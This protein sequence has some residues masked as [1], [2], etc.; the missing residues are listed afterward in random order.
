MALD[1]RFIP[2]FYF[3]E[4]LRDKVTGLPLSNGIVTFYKDQAR[5]EL[6]KIYRISGTPPNYQYD[7]LPNPLT[8]SSVG[9]F[10]D[11]SGND[12]VVYFFPYDTEPDEPTGNIELYYITVEDEL[13]NPQWDR[14]GQPNIDESSI[15]TLNDDNFI[16]NAQFRLFKSS[17]ITLDETSIKNIAYLWDFEKSNT[18]GT[19][20]ATLTEF[21]TNLDVEGT[22]T[23][24]VNYACTSA[25]TGESYKDFVYTIPDVNT[26][27]NK[28]IR[29]SLLA[30][31]TSGAPITIEFKQYFGSGGSADVDATLATFTLTPVFTKY[32]SSAYTVPSVSGK[33]IGSG[34]YIQLRIRMPLNS[35]SSVDFTNAQLNL[36]TDI[37]TFKQLEYERNV[38]ETIGSLLPIP[39]DNDCFSRL[40]WNGEQFVFDNETGKLYMGFD[41]ERSGYILCN[42]ATYKSGDYV[43]DSNNKVKYRRLWQHWEE[44]TGDTLMSGN[45]FGYGTNG[46][47]PSVRYNNFATFIITK[48]KTAITAWADGTTGFS[49]SQF[50]VGADYGCTTTLSFNFELTGTNYKY[51]PP[52]YSFVVENDTVG[53]VGAP[54]VGTMPGSF[55]I[56]ILQTGDATHAQIAQ[57]EFDYSPADI[58]SLGGKYFTYT[59]VT[60]SLYVWFRV[61]DAGTDPAPG[62]T[63]IMV[64]IDSS[65]IQDGQSLS[66]LVA[67]MMNGCGTNTVTFTDA[68]SITPGSY[69]TIYNDGE[70]YVFYYVIDGV[71]SAP[72]VPGATA[73]IN[74]EIE[75]SWVAGQVMAQTEKEIR[76]I[77]FQVP[78]FRGLGVRGTD[79]SR[80][81]DPNAADRYTR[82]DMIGRDHV[83][84]L[85]RDE[86]R[87]HDHEVK[88]DFTHDVDAAVNWYGYVKNSDDY[89]PEVT[90]AVGGDESRMVNMN[91]NIFVKY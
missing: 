54:T 74:I 12:I 45:A 7:E 71:G 13:S 37:Y 17:S 73:I 14:E 91:V 89:G 10:M 85:Q 40:V 9:T 43:P 23:Y 57:I 36:G 65:H 35:I 21:P 70:N 67:Y 26:F 69:F 50:M 90:S 11:N 79:S 4:T 19:D 30:R 72:T 25:G 41:S 39:T 42:G 48:P 28:T 8:L 6:K 24:Y 32:S 82:G 59:T 2:A 86:F 58:A 20:T 66:Y 87:N 63:G 22:P 56:N 80:G 52:S 46:F 33:T 5:T 15:D 81:I 51:Y 44:D 88:G 83:G 64:D 18:S 47:C 16:L 76:S 84:S 55:A 1:T 60:T 68:S 29:F 34:S 77:Y 62:G 31:E 78:D 3:Q 27:Q 75:G 38:A 61:D 53:A 49:F